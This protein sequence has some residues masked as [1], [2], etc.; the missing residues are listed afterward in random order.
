[1]NVTTEVN[2][3]ALGNLVLW[4]MGEDHTFSF[5]QIHNVHPHPPVGIIM[6]TIMVATYQEPFFQPVSELVREPMFEIAPGSIGRAVKQIT[7]KR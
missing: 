1:M 2:G 5:P 3:H 7:E 4:I 6:S